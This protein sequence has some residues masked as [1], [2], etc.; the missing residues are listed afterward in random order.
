M[1][2]TGFLAITIEMLEISE[3]KQLAAKKELERKGDSVKSGL[4]ELQRRTCVL[5]VQHVLIFKRSDLQPICG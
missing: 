1:V 2:S 4:T 3:R 5:L